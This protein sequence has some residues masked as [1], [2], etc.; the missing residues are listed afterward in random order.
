MVVCFVFVFAAPVAE[1]SASGLGVQTFS[2]VASNK[3]G[4]VDMQAGSH[5]YQLTTTFFLNGPERGQPLG[6]PEELLLQD[7]LKDARVELPPGLVGNP[8]ATPRCNY[9]VFSAI[10]FSCAPSTS[11]TP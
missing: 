6:K 11:V 3:D 4:T 10:R 2:M 5:P 1:S 8:D 9:Q 7:D